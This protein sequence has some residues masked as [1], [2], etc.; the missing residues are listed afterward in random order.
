[1][2]VIDASA[3]LHILISPAQNPQTLEKIM[4]G[5]ALHAPH[6][7]DSEILNALRLRVLLKEITAARAQEIVADLNEFTIGRWPM[8]PLNQRV[9]ELRHNLTAYDASYVALAENLKVPLYTRDAK[10]AHAPVRGVE[11]VLV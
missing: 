6:L 4:A 7:I 9:W 2:I 11:I 3:L 8:H 5:G 10:L 1:M